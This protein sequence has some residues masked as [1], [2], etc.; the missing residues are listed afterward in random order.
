MIEV[1]KKSYFLKKEPKKNYKKFIFLKKTLWLFF[2]KLEIT[3]NED[4]NY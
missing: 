1:R 3:R 4:H 2:S